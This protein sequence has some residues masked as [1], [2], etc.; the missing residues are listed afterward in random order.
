MNKMN[1]SAYKNS[2]II[3][4][5]EQL[6][7]FRTSAQVSCYHST[8][9]SKLSYKKARNITGSD[10]MTSLCYCSNTTTGQPPVVPSSSGSPQHA[11][12]PFI[13]PSK[14][15]AVPPAHPSCSCVIPRSP[16]IRE[17]TVG[18]KLSLGSSQHINWIN[19]SMKPRANHWM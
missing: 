8:Q 3:K 17:I 14:A 6:E 2:I 15:I 19:Y 16:I 4:K 9:S 13:R 5:N 7:H 18:E 12:K 1:C 11:F 10:C